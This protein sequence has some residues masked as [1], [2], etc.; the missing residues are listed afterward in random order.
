MSESYKRYPFEYDIPPVPPENSFGII[1]TPGPVAITPDMVND[2]LTFTSSDG[3][4]T[5]TGTEATDT[6]DL[7]VPGWPIIDITK[8]AE[9]AISDRDVV[10]IS[11]A[12]KISPAIAN[13]VSKFRAIGFA[14]NSALA[15]GLVTVRIG[16]VVDSLAGLT[17]NDFVWLSPASSG[18]VTPSIPGGSGDFLVKLGV[19]LTTTSL[20]LAIEPI[21]RRA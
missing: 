7:T 10:Y 5:I 11:S 6:I 9:V 18:D 2:T 15:G 8:E 16:G 20:V 19:A 4:V 21:A 3:S 1:I 12:D 14:M 13:D 17:V